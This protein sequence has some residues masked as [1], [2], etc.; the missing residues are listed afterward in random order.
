MGEK[1]MKTGEL[2]IKDLK[3]GEM[4]KFDGVKPVDLEPDDLE[5]AAHEQPTAELQEY[6]PDGINIYITGSEISRVSN[7][8]IYFKEDE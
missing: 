5:P 8:E 1:N 6:V 4:F 3:T 7:I 2:F